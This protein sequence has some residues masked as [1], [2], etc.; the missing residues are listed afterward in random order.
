MVE[1]EGILNRK[2]AVDQLQCV[3]VIAR[4]K[5]AA[6]SIAYDDICAVSTPAAQSISQGRNVRGTAI[7][8][9]GA[10]ISLRC[11]R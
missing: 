4:S 1:S 7:E 3:M 8:Q 9:R 6:L 2:R 11:R 10:Q 5:I